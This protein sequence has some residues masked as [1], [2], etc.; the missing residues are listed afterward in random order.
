MGGFIAQQLTLR[1]PARVT[2]L[3]LLATDPGGPDS[4]SADP[5]VWSRLTDHS[6]SPRE[7]ATRLIS[8]LFPSPLAEQIDA[9]FGDLVAAARAA[10]DP[11]VLRAQEAAMEAWHRDG[12]PAPNHGET[13]PTLILHGDL[14]QVI[15]AAN[16]EPLAAH[17]PGA[18][19]EILEGCG[20]ALMAQEPSLAAS[21]IAAT[22]ASTRP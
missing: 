6:G 18:Q 15:P 8:L 19:V 10:L 13:P 14:D 2:S 22:R 7:Q 3:T 12:A 16:S 1:A 11:A 20:H 21:L 17:W 4:V 5:A 9:E